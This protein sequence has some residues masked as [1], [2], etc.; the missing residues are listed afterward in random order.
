[1]IQHDA[2]MLLP[3]RVAGYFRESV[4][5]KFLAETAHDNHSEGIGLYYLFSLIQRKNGQNI[6]QGCC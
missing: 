1:M 3:L 5:H 4:A 2:A 6:K